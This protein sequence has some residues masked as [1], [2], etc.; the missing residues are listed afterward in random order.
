VA[1]VKME[2][3][4]KKVGNEYINNFLTRQLNNPNLTSDPVRLGDIE[5]NSQNTE[6]FVELK[7]IESTTTTTDGDII[8]NYKPTT[9]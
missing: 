6:L 1:K 8:E 3:L 7:A 5:Y 9:E 4:G 2:I